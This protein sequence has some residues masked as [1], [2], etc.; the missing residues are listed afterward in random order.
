MKFLLRKNS[1]QFLYL[2][3]NVEQM[4][5]TR[6]L[7]ETQHTSGPDFEN[8]SEQDRNK[9]L[10]TQLE[11]QL[12]CEDIIKNHDKYVEEDI[13]RKLHFPRQ[14]TIEDFTCPISHK[15]FID[16]VFFVDHFYERSHIETSPLIHYARDDYGN[17]FKIEP[18]PRFFLEELNK[19]KA[20]HGTE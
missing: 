2:N 17:P 11:F 18:A 12:R 13:K 14:L 4:E 20:T 7:F 9:M 5:V 10:A 1:Q 16:P 15:I 8:M 6:Y 19:F 3:Y